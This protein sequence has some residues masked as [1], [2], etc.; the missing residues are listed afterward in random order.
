MSIIEESSQSSLSSN[1]EFS[2]NYWNPYFFY[3]Y[4]L[5]SGFIRFYYDDVVSVSTFYVCNPVDVD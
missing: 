2:L 4:L 3:C 1:I 5:L